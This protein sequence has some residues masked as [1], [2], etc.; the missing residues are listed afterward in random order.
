MAARL[1]SDSAALGAGLL[2]YTAP[3]QYFDVLALP[4]ASMLLASTAGLHL[5]W[6]AAGRPAVVLGATCF[7]LSILYKPIALAAA[8]AT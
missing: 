6:F 5:I 8:L 1:I 3:L 4:Y 2:F 7:A